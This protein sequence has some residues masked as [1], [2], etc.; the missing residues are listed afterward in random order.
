M[1]KGSNKNKFKSIV[2]KMTVEAILLFEELE[3]CFSTVLM[4]IHFN[5]QQQLM[6]KT[7]LSS[8]VLRE[9]LSQLIKKSE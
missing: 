1:L 8:E 3:R 7:N 5:S 2:F 9:I 6:L 4:L